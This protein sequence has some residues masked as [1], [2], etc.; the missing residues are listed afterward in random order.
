MYLWTTKGRLAE[1][2]FSAL[3]HGEKWGVIFERF[4]SETPSEHPDVRE[5]RRVVSGRVVAVAGGRQRQ[6]W[7]PGAQAHPLWETRRGGNSRSHQE[8]LG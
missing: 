7:A 1:L 2:L 5:A 8:P 3:F 4:A 6:S